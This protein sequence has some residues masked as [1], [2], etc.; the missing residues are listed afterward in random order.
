MNIVN[1]VLGQTFFFCAGARAS[2]KLDYTRPSCLWFPHD[3]VQIYT[4]KV[5]DSIFWPGLFPGTVTSLSL[6]VVDMKSKKNQ[7]SKLD[8]GRGRGRGKPEHKGSFIAQLRCDC[9]NGLC[10]PSRP[11]KSHHSGYQ[12]MTTSARLGRLAITLRCE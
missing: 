12:I 5:A 11:C 4:V 8:Q 1:K 3:L 7:E 6:I 10:R 9:M 2:L